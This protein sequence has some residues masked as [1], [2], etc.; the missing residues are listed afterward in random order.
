[1]RAVH[2][3]GASLTDLRAFPDDVQDEIGHALLKAQRGG[4][5]SKA[6]P[7]QGFHGAG[8]LEIV[9]N[10]DGDTYRAVYTVKMAAAIYVL[11]CFQKKSKRG[12]A[13]PK[14]DL[15]LIE[16]RMKLAVADAKGRNA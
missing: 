13:T 8:V 12:V 2:W 14:H 11:H 10:H 3:M 15:D 7:L 4:K 1:M 5:S 16:Q 9:E 6:K